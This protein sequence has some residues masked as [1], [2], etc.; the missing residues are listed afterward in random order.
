MIQ[1]PANATSQ[2]S[3]VANPDGSITKSIRLEGSA[4]AGGES[5]SIRSMYRRSSF[6]VTRNPFRRVLAPLLSGALALVVAACS[7]NAVAIPSNLFV[8]AKKPN[9]WPTPPVAKPQAPPRIVAMWMPTLTLHPGMWFD[10]TIVV[11]TNVASV[12]VRT[13]AFS[14]N[15]THVAPGLY[16]FHTRVLELPPFSRRHSYELDVIAR[17][18]A[19]VKQVE[20]APLRVE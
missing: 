7:P 8:G 9:A 19:G 15:S 20:Q 3:R 5:D 17:N 11:S 4:S 13:A 1:T 2:S 6:D 18:T 12:E 14:V 10:G 16:R